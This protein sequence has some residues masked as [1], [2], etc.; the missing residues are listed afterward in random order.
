MTFKKLM[1]KEGLEYDHVYDWVIQNPSPEGG[2]IGH[3]SVESFDEI[4]HSNRKHG[5]NKM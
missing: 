4:K 3:F 2:H 1:R 5:K